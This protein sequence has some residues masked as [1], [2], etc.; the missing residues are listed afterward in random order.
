MICKDLIMVLL[1]SDGQTDGRT[2]RKTVTVGPT[3]PCTGQKRVFQASDGQTDRW[4]DGR[5]REN[6]NVL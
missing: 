5:L 3:D 6:I 1:W 4:T 2:C